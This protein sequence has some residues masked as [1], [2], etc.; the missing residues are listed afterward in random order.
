MR[1]RPRRRRAENRTRTWAPPTGRVARPAAGDGAQ[2]R[3]RL[4]RRRLVRHRSARRAVPAIPAVDNAEKETRP[5]VWSVAGLARANAHVVSRATAARPTAARRRTKRHRRHPPISRRAASQV[6]LTPFMLM[7]IAAGNALPDPYATA[8]QARLSLARP[9]HLRLRPPAAPA[10]PTRRPRPRPRSQRSSAPPRPPTSR[11]SGETVVYCRPRRVVL[12]PHGPALCQPRQAAGGVDAFMIGSE[13][14]GLT[15][16]A[17]RPSAY[18]RRSPGA[19][20]ADVK[21][22]LGGG[23]QRHLRRRLVGVSRP[24]ARRRHGR[25][26]FP[27]RSRCGP[28]RR[29]TPSAS[30]STPRSPTGATARPSRP[31]AGDRSSTTSITQAQPLRRRRLR[32]VLRQRRRPR[33][34][35]RT[36]SP[37]APASPGCFVEGYPKLVEQRAL[38]PPRRREAATPTAWVPQSKPIWFTEIGCPAVD[39]GANQPNVFLDPKSPNRRC[40][41][42]PTAR[43]TT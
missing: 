22:I 38:R 12:P 20:A 43:A 14:R 3:R 2:H 16:R 7:D 27:S 18:P 10:R 32:L 25:R 36:P 26:P 39:Q 19:L 4:A 1:T 40:P 21:A 31:R 6:T 5:L 37:T 33:R 23:H 9:H 15:Q 30:I 28:R 35:I 29:S 8:P 41:I 42:S 11:S 24:P 17:Q 34:Q 13:L